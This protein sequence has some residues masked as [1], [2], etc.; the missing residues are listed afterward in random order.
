M[1]IRCGIAGLQ[2]MGC[3]LAFPRCHCSP[4]PNK[5]IVIITPLISAQAPHSR[6]GISGPVG[7]C[8]KCSFLRVESAVLAMG[9]VLFS[10]INLM[11]SHCFFFVCV[12]MHVCALDW[13]NP[14]TDD[15][16]EDELPPIIS[17]GLTNQTHLPEALARA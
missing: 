10:L 13:A 4:E 15:F 11:S 3:C 2:G 7:T 1:F 6:I 12:G 8:A 5:N 9:S 14:Q 17:V 16:I